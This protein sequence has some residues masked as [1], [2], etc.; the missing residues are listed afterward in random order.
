MAGDAPPRRR[1]FGS[2]ETRDDDACIPA[3]R[4]CHVMREPHL[5]VERSQ[6]APEVG[7]HRL[8]LDDQQRPGCWMEGEQVDTAAL[9]VMAERDLGPHDPAGRLEQLRKAGLESGVARIEQSVQ[10]AAAP[11]A[12]HLEVDVEGLADPAKCPHRKAD[13]SLALELRDGAPADP[14]SASEVRL[15][16]SEAKTER[17]NDLAE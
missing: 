17:A 13:R 2:D 11:S 7:D 14:G 8:D 16:P 1:V 3:E 9:A 15:T 5:H 4:P 6:Q 10:L 12:I